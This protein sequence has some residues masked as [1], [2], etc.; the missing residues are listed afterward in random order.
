M[1]PI[2]FSN[3]TAQG[4]PELFITQCNLT[5]RLYYWRHNLFESLNIEK[6]S[7]CLTSAFTLTEQHSW[8]WK[9]LSM[10]LEEKSNQYHPDISLE[11]LQLWSACK[12]HWWDSDINVTCYPTTFWLYLNPLH[13]MEPRPD[14]DS[15]PRAKSILLLCKW[16]VPIKCFLMTSFSIHKLEHSNLIREAYPCSI[17]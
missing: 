11:T 17:C 14:L 5:G 12:I 9:V 15:V 16:S 1:S 8:Y 13:G 10:L 7:W 3:V 4:S 2:D 6:F